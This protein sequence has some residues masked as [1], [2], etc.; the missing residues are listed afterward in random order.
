MKTRV[1]T[2]SRVALKRR[3]WIHFQVMKTYSSR[4]YA[5]YAF[6]LE[7][8]FPVNGVDGLTVLFYS[9]SEGYN[10]STYM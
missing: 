8:M 3:T 6:P 1:Q 2:Q 7:I 9:P 5:Y 10:A 4:I